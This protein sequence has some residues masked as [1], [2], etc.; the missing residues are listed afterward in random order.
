MINL[1]GKPIRW[2]V[3]KNELVLN[4]SFLD[5]EQIKKIEQLFQDGKICKIIIKDSA[6][7]SKTKK[8]QDKYYATL[9]SI[10]KASNEPVTSDSLDI[11]D[12]FVREN[13]FPAKYREIGGTQIPYVP[14]MKELSMREMADVIRAILSRYD[15]LLEDLKENYHER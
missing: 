4:L 5:N 2:D 3:D 6:R 11:L 13:F 15:F 10:L 1:M 8:Q 9:R 12:N 7:I 14:R